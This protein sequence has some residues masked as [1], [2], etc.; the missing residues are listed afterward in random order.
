MQSVNFLLVNLDCLRMLRSIPPPDALLFDIFLKIFSTSL[1]ATAFTENVSCV[2]YLILIF[3]ILEWSSNFFIIVVRFPFCMLSYFSLEGSLN[4]FNF[5][6]T[7]EKW[8]L[9]VLVILSLFIC[10]FSFCT[11]SFLFV[12][13]FS[14]SIRIILES[15]WAC[16]FEK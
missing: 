14:F 11:T 13:M 15:P 2:A 8:L 7:S 16:S 4:V 12:M 1:T 9:R 6:T 5:F 3:I 10:K